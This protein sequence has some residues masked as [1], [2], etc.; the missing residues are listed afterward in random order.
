MALAR[1]RLGGVYLWHDTEGW[2]LRVVRLGRVRQVFSG[3]LRTDASLRL[4]AK[5]SLERD[6]LVAVG[7][8]SLQFRLHPGGDS[9]GFD[10]EATCARELTFFLQPSRARSPT[11]TIY[12]GS[13]ARA[14][15][16]WFTI[17]RAPAVSGIAGRLT[18]G[19]AC[20]VEPCPNTDR[21]RPAE[22]EVKTVRGRRVATFVTDAEGRFRVEVPP[23]VYLI[24]PLGLSS[25]GADVPATPRIVVRAGILTRVTL[26]FDTGIR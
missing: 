10:F 11:P 3:H 25:D 2:H 26:T 8:R 22:Y 21:G 6:D 12:L 23:G 16:S 20:P 5:D 24:A 18:L 7:E 14:P 13:A 19:P 17:A 9:D 1:G 4:L 15:S